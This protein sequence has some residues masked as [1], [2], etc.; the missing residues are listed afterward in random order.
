MVMPGQVF[1]NCTACLRS[2]AAATRISAA[3]LRSASDIMANS[4]VGWAE[5]S[6][7]HAVKHQ[8]VIAWARRSAPLPTLRNC[9]DMDGR[10]KPG[11]D[12]NL[13]FTLAQ[14]AK[15]KPQRY[16]QAARNTIVST[17]HAALAGR[18]AWPCSQSEALH[19]SAVRTSSG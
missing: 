17:G 6:E 14:L 2:C 3:L 18:W 12:G 8:N 19:F 11:H 10:D 16:W 15:A 9:N 1:D 7:A 4:F 5:R 13:K